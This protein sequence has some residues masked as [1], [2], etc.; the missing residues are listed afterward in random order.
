MQQK[1]AS[2]EEISLPIAVFTHGLS[3][4]TIGA[5]AAIVAMG[6]NKMPDS[7]DLEANAKEVKK[8]SALLRKKGILSHTIEGDTFRLKFNFTQ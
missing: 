6:G 4:S 1:L 8:A 7:F 3:L 2:N 5:I